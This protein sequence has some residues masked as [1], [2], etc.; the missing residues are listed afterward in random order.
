M[1]LGEPVWKQESAQHLRFGSS[2]CSIIPHL[3]AQASRAFK[4]GITCPCWT[5]K[6][7]KPYRWWRFYSYIYYYYYFHSD[8]YHHRNGSSERSE[9]TQACV[10]LLYMYIAG[11]ALFWNVLCVITAAVLQCLHE[12]VYVHNDNY[13]VL[14]V[15]KLHVCYVWNKDSEWMYCS[16]WQKDR[17]N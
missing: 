8:A 10:G 2:G 7:I 9:Q 16:W 15:L 5:T 6:T 11:A 17:L 4:W 1:E 3:K 12:V 13:L 14:S